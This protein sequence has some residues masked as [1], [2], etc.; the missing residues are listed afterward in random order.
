MLPPRVSAKKSFRC[1]SDYVVASVREGLGGVQ[2]AGSALSQLAIIL[3]GAKDWP[4]LTPTRS[5]HQT[6]SIKHCS[7]RA[8]TRCCSDTPESPQPAVL[9]PSAAAPSSRAR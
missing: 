6:R 2:A 8:P 5:C 7:C 1:G 9:H 4:A 3:Q